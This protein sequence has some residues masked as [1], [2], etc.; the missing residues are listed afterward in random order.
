MQRFRNTGVGLLVVSMLVV[1]ISL[2]HNTYAQAPDQ[3]P[4]EGQIVKLAGNVHAIYDFRAKTV[5]VIF[6]DN[7]DVRS[8]H[9]YSYDKDYTR[10]PAQAPAPAH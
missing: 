2:I 4:Q 7:F 1:A 3:P 6:Y 8:I 5:S 9:V 10:P